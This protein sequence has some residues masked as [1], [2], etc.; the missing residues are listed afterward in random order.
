[1]FL[2]RGFQ[3]LQVGFPMKKT[4]LLEAQ[5]PVDETDVPCGVG[6]GPGGWRFGL[7]KIKN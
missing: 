1:M 3:T 4:L 6:Q 5:V 7:S 2:S